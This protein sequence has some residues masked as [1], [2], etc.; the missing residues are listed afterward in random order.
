M[1]IPDKKKIIGER[2]KIAEEVK[3]ADYDPLYEKNELGKIK[4]DHKRTAHVMVKFINT[5][6]RITGVMRRIMTLRLLGTAPDYRPLSMM[7]TALAMAIRKEDVE[8]IEKEGVGIVSQ[9]LERVSLQE[10][11]DKFNQNSRNA[12]DLKNDIAEP[13]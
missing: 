12:R 4:V 9:E 6:P 8:R 7:E 11:I 2:K 10:G 5:S 13:S 3:D 1:A